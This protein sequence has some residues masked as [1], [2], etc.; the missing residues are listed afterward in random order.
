MMNVTPLAAPDTELAARLRL[1]VTRVARRLRQQTPDPITASQLSAL[2]VIEKAGPVTLGELARLEQVQCPSMTRIAA[3][4]ETQGLVT[5]EVDVADRRI[6]RMRVTADGRRLLARSRRH[7]T[8]Y[9]AAAL[10]T[11]TPEERAVL[12][13]AAVLLERMVADR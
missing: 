5:R 2:V 11:F 3:A 10:R 7:K 8:A 4:L 9:L 13:Q 1:A 6:A 12:D